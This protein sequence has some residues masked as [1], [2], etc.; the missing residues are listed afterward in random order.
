MHPKATVAH[1]AGRPEGA[2]VFS[3]AALSQKLKSRLELET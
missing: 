3:Q 1:F 2:L